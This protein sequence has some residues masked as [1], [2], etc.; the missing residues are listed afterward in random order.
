MGLAHGRVRLC[1]F[2]AGSRTA[3]AILKSSAQAA[4]LIIAT[5][6]STAIPSRRKEPR[7]CFA[8]RLLDRL[9]ADG[10]VFFSVIARKSGEDGNQYKQNNQG[11]GSD[12]N[13]VKRH[14]KS[15]LFH[16]L[17]FHFLLFKCISKG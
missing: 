5:G 14:L 2:A 12:D 4:I 15:F 6:G 1:L 11:Q 17:I 7:A 9:V 13:G 16:V 3:A 8:F 10:F